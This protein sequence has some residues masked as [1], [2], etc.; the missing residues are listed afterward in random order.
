MSLLFQV[1][2]RLVAL[3]ILCLS[4]SAVAEE[5]PDALGILKSVRVAQAAQNRALRGELRNAGKTVPFRLSMTAG[6][7]RYEF[8]AP[9]FTLQLRLGEKS[10]RFEEV[11]KG[12]TEKITPARFDTRVRDTDLSYEDLSLRFLYWPKAEVVGEQI[13]VLQKCWIVRV[14]PGSAKDSQYGSVKLWIAKNSGALMQAEAY[15]DAGKFVRR[16]KVI[17]GQKTDD[18]LWILKEMR[19]EWVDPGKSRD[20]TPTYLNIDSVE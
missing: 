2:T 3:G 7:I 13:M 12:G 19:I 6:V 9:P 14:E 5:T 17:S 15:D 1:K 11:T 20:R 4:G 16:F 10:S 8:T 18:G